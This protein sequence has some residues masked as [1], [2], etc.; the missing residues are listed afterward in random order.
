MAGGLRFARCNTY[1]G[2]S[3]VQQYLIRH[4]NVVTDVFKNASSLGRDGPDSIN[5]IEYTG[6][7]GFEFVPGMQ[8]VHFRAKPGGRH[9]GNRVWSQAASPG[10]RDKLAIRARRMRS[11]SVTREGVRG[12]SSKPP[13]VIYSN[14]RIRIIQPWNSYLSSISWAAT[15]FMRKRERDPHTDQ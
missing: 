10:V 4:D 12:A 11:P 3:T 15:S 13:P 7:L 1:C 8:P 2:W 9:H 6:P 5:L 14:T